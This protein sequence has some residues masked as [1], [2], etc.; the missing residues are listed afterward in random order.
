MRPLLADGESNQM[1][2]VADGIYSWTAPSWSNK[3]K[4]MPSRVWMR[5]SLRSRRRRNASRFTL[6]AKM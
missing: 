2:Y 5:V 1:P 3:G 6:M 4:P